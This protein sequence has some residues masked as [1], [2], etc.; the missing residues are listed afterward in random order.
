M[1]ERQAAR[2]GLRLV[3]SEVFGDKGEPRTASGVLPATPNPGAIRSGVLVNGKYLVG[4]LLGEGGVGLVFEAKNVELDEKVA[5]KCLRP[6][7]LVDTAMVARFAREAKAAASIKSEYVATVHDVGT[8][9]DGSPFMVMELLDGQDLGA[10]VHD[11]G[12]LG[13]RAVSECGLQVCEA[14]AVAHSKGIIHRDIKPEN[15]MLTERAGGMRIVKVLD[16]GISKAALTGSIF[17]NDLPLV[18]TVSLM[19]TPLY[20]SP[21][22]IRSSDSADVRS[23]IWSLGMVLYELLTGTTAFSAGT[24]TELC[25]AILESTPQPITAHRADVPEGL[26]AVVHRCLEKD[27]ARRYQNVGEL[28]LALL[29][30]APKRARLNVERSIAV[31]KG[32]G[33]VDAA[34]RVHSTRPPEALESVE[35]P[36]IPSAPRL[37]TP[38]SLDIVHSAASTGESAALAP[39]RR[40]P[41]VLGG[42]VIAVVAA[43]AAAF[44]VR[45]SQVAPAHTVTSEAH[46]VSA[47]QASSP[48]AATSV[49]PVTVAPSGEP[50]APVEKSASAAAVAPR[51]PATGQ[52]SPVPMAGGKLRA[53]AATATGRA[54]GKPAAAGS[55]APAGT[56]EEPDLGY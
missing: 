45:T 15:L 54:A 47:A 11:R 46:P 29:P 37:P 33:L 24:I 28:A 6:E 8:M 5:L 3:A 26:V 30:F 20:M 17:Q 7:V 39:R 23:D 34:V 40:A 1:D 13:A 35:A 16:F 12:A 10:L 44:A 49:A 22:Q 48:A 43:A 21:E 51:G 52:A 36:K 27:P 18:K 41:L 56:S 9:T 55:T 53:P 42:I 50:P 38:A 14:L 31:L 4:R 32:A 25:A 19:G 2:Q